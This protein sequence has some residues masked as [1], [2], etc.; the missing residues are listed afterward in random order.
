MTARGD[1]NGK[2]TSHLRA[3]SL[4]LSRCRSAR[5]VDWLPGSASRGREKTRGSWR[6]GEGGGKETVF[7]G[8]GG[9][10]VYVCMNVCMGEY[11]F[12]LC[13]Y[14]CVF[15]SMYVSVL[16][17]CGCVCACVLLNYNTLITD[18]DR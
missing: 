9:G 11:M 5:V 1:T 10:Y 17:W 4:A 13:M 3:V 2:T 15:V 8:G 18:S 16:C 12:V 14:V 7:G 6:G